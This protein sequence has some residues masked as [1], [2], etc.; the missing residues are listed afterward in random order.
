MAREIKWGMYSAA[1]VDGSGHHEIDLHPALSF[2]D[3]LCGLMG[4]REV[5]HGVGMLF[6]RCTSLHCLWMRVPIDVL[7][8]AQP[9]DQGRCKVTGYIRSMRPWTIALSPRGTWGALEMASESFATAPC[10]VE[11]PPMRGL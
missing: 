11:L 7:W 6:P 9:D 2:T 3:R 8:L 4:Q 1:V 10:R 5:P